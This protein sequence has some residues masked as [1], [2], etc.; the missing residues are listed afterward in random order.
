MF[1][2]L[3]YIQNNSKFKNNGFDNTPDFLLISFFQKIILKDSQVILDQNRTLN[4]TTNINELI[5]HFKLTLGITK[6]Q[7]KALNELSM[8]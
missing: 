2:S 3:I 4:F 1:S 6:N 5:I 7:T 8:L